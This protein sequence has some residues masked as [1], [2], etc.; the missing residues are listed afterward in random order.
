MKNG[1][2]PSDVPTFLEHQR[3][4]NVSPQLNLAVF[5]VR[6]TSFQRT[7]FPKRVCS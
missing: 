6:L 2:M 3:K 7:G 1:K 5:Q 4:V